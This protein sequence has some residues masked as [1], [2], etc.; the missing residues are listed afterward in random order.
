MNKK[1][2]LLILGLI[3]TLILIFLVVY[4]LDLP[5]VFKS[6]FNIPCPACGMS[7]ALR[8]IFKLEIAKSFSYNILA[9]PIIII[10]IICIF[11]ASYDI[12]KKS[13]LL[14]NFINFLFT[15][16][17]LIMIFLF[18]SWVINIIRKI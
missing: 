9:F 2:K 7:R 4:K 13:N 3:I 17:Y 14:Y 8:S 5:C 18:I 1:N 6:I 11:L 15:N 10:I 12:I 16:Y